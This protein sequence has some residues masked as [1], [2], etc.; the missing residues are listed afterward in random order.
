MLRAAFLFCGDRV[1]VKAPVEANVST[2]LDKVAVRDEDS[3]AVE[4]D[5]SCIL[6]FPSNSPSHSLILR[7]KSRAR[8]DNCSQVFGLARSSDTPPDLLPVPHHQ[9]SVK[10]NRLK[11]LKADVGTHSIQ[12]W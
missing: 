1:F 10:E 8:G 12:R 4:A 9:M 6:L 7:Y 2:I 3:R 5:V 11:I